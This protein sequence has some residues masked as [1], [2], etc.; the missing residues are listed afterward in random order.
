MNDCSLIVSRVTETDSKQ[1]TLSPT[2]T[3]ASVLGIK[4]ADGVIIAADTLVS[5][6]SLARY[7]DF[8]RVSVINDNTVMACSGDIA[9]YQLLKRRIEEQTHTDGLL[10]DGF[11]LRCRMNP[12]WNTY[13]VGGRESN[14]KPFLGYCDLLGVSFADDCLASGFGTYLALP[15]LRQRLAD[16]AGGDP[17]KFTQEN[18]MQAIVDGMRQLYY[19]DCR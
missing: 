2:C 14:G 7:L 17:E 16:Q 10:S 1:H 18:A 15:L 5:Y 11:T 13:I 3:G 19:R 4:Y 8:E 6:G 9:D 12:L